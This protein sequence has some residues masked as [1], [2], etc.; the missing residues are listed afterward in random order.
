MTTET[1]GAARI[2]RLNDIARRIPALANATWLMTRGVNALLIGDD[3]ADLPDDLHNRVALLYQTI[4][5][6][7]R[8][9][10]RNDPH[11]EHDFGDFEFLGH[12]LYFKIDYY[13]P[14]RDV[15]SP[16]PSNIELC[17]RVLTIMLV[18]E[19]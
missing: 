7:D 6:Y 4:A 17:R 3:P 9:S 19:Y 13:H 14:G 2:R 1:N 10:E 11:G 8:F 5:G 18:E 12:A 16:D 15:L